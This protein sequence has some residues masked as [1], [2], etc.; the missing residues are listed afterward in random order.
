MLCINDIMDQ[1]KPQHM[2]SCKRFCVQTETNCWIRDEARSL[3][4]DMK[5]RTHRG[6]VI[7]WYG[8]SKN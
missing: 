3:K 6:V 8:P 7:E 2:L 1:G 5:I 4:Q